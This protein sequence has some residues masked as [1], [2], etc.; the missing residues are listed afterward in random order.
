M[1]KKVF[2]FVLAISILALFRQLRRSSQRS[3]ESVSLLQVAH[4][5]R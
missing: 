3:P 5:T 2:L 4:G 1:I